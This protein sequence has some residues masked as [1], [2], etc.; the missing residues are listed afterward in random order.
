LERHGR[1]KRCAH[2]HDRTGVDRV[3]DSAKILFF[4][5]AVRAGGTARLA[6][7]AAIVCDDLESA[8]GEAVDDSGG[9]RTIVGDAVQVDQ[10]APATCLTDGV[11]SRTERT[12]IPRSPAAP[13]LELN[14]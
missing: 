6:M 13:S 1:A 7:R 8:P 4:I 2:Q 11:T 9:A 14:A 12:R 3:H 5:E 10:R